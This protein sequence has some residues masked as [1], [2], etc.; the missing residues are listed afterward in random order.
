MMLVLPPCA[1]AAVLA[2]FAW[3]AANKIDG[4]A[5][6][7]ERTVLE[8][9]ITDRLAQFSKEQYS[10]TSWDEAVVKVKQ[11]D[12]VWISE[13]LTTWLCEFYS[14]DEVIIVDPQNNPIYNC[15]I[16]YINYSD[17]LGKISD[18]MPILSDIR[19]NLKDTKDFYNA[20]LLGLTL[21]KG[22]PAMI[23]IR[24]IVPSDKNISLKPAEAYLHIDIQYLDGSILRTIGA[25]YKLN[26]V[27]F[28]EL[29]DG[30][31]PS[32]FLPLSAVEGEPIGFLV[33]NVDT[34]GHD[35]L[36]QT[37]PG[38]LA[39]AILI[40]GLVGWL[41]FRLF[42]SASDL[43]RQ[44]REA[45]HLAY[46]DP[47]TG[48]ANRAMMN[49]RLDR[50][51]LKPWPGQSTFALHYLDLDRFK[52]VNDT[53]GHPAGDDLIQQVAD[54]LRSAIGPNDLVARLGGDEFAIVQCNLPSRNQA[55]ALADSILRSLRLPFDLDGNLAFIDGSIGIAPAIESDSRAEIVRRADIALYQVKGNGKGHYCFFE[56]RFDDA[57]LLRRQIESDL[58]EALESQSGLTLLFQPYFAADGRTIRGAEALL[59]WDH[60]TL[61]DIDP[62]LFISVAEE[63]GM[64]P[65]LGH[66]VFRKAIEVACRANLPSVA[67]NVS[68]AQ[69]RDENLAD[70]ILDL[71]HEY[72]L[73]PERLRLEITEGLLLDSTH[74]IGRSLTKL[75]FAGVQISLD[76]FGTGYS[77]LNHLR[78]YKVDAIKID[79]SF[80]QNL[81]APDNTDAIL[82]AILD[83]ARALHHEVIAEGVETEY[84]WNWLVAIGCTE[85]QG[86]FL[87]KPLTIN[88]L[89]AIN[90][91]MGNL[92]LSGNPPA[93]RIG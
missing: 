3:W 64:M 7:R 71:V 28:A 87:C 66:W 18:F 37:A 34:P 80:V 8:S 78:R 29:R 45:I 43:A 49:A 55:A 51:C 19:Q 21:Y 76:D 70:R 4:F 91:D 84:Q 9:A 20:S 50:E 56:R 40:A 89:Y 39:V 27:R 93:L 88:D 35:L 1:A 79:K 42:R 47:L 63:R 46:H 22:H 48:L 25:R 36:K 44:Q 86:F 16:N 12:S 73:S 6:E 15:K 17:I 33:W 65:R 83:L 5:Y 11:G 61:G 58:H 52:H 62:E 72:G 10:V 32:A 53:L 90:M 81:G 92:S 82:R 68:A 38:F 69:F 75:R 57:Q 2:V 59:R 24:P 54:R 26:R 14:H 31:P 74:C 60:P 67:V 41:M 13:N 23:A 85:F 77:S 30:N